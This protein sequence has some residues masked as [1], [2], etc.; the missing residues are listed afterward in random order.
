MEAS[1]DKQESMAN[2]AELEKRLGEDTP[3]GRLA[4]ARSVDLAAILASVESSAPRAARIEG[5]PRLVGDRG[6]QA[7]PSRS[8]AFILVPEEELRC[9]CGRKG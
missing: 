5:G 3:S 9:I 2:Q 7:A 8:T 4:A 1:F 6:D